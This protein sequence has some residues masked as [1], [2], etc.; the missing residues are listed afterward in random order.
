V[1]IGVAP[2]VPFYIFTNVQCNW[3]KI[4]NDEATLW[5]SNFDINKFINKLDVLSI[6]EE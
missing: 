4:V 3:V 2:I 6:Q 1:E 5:A